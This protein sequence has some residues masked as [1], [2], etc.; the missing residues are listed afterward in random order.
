MALNYL[1]DFMKDFGRIWI[2][3]CNTLPGSTLDVNVQLLQ[4][5]SGLNLPNA[6]RACRANASIT[7]QYVCLLHSIEALN[8]FIQ[9][10]LSLLLA[11]RAIVVFSGTGL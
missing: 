1:S 7:C 11:F 6:V 2:T 4:R 8:G 5:V 3:D 10:L 9:Y